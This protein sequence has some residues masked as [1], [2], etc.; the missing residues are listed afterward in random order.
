MTTPPLLTSVLAVPSSAYDP[1]DACYA[2]AA[3][4][5]RAGLPFAIESADRQNPRNL[6][7][8]AAMACA[9]GLPHEEAVRAVTLYAA[10]TLGLEQELGSLTVG[11]RGDVIVSAGDLLDIRAKVELVFIDGVQQSMKNRQSE[12]YERYKARLER[13]RTKK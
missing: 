6:A 10:R 2:N 9:F 8:H 3:V 13:M 7:F 11:K 1:Y 12:L 4:L 5:A